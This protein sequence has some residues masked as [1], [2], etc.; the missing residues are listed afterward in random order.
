MRTEIRRLREYQQHCRKVLDALAAKNDSADILDRLRNGEAIDE[1]SR[2]LEAS[3]MS[4]TPSQPLPDG[5]PDTLNSTP[6]FPS[7]Q[8]SPFLFEDFLERSPNQSGVGPAIS[9]GQQIILGDNIDSQDLP[10]DDGPK[11]TR[12]TW[13]AVTSDTVMLSLCTCSI[14][15]LS[16]HIALPPKPAIIQNVEDALWIPYT[17]DGEPLDR[18]FDQPSNLRS[19]YKTFCEL[20]EI[21]HQALYTLYSPGF[22][23]T[24]GSLIKVYNSYIEWYDTIPDSLRLGQNFTPSVLFAHLFYHSATLLLFQPFI[25]LK[26]LTSAVLPRE[27]CTQA[28]DAITGLVKSYSDLYTLRR[29]PS[30]VPF[31]VLQSSIIH[32]LGLKHNPSDTSVRQKF[33]Q[34]ISG[35]KEMARCHGFALRAIDVVQ[36]FARH[37]KVDVDDEIGTSSRDFDRAALL[38]FFSVDVGALGLLQS[39]DTELAEEILPLFSPFPMQ[40]IPM[41]KMGGEVEKD[42]F[43]RHKQGGI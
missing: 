40:G 15:H 31:F 14:P 12:E 1:I 24:S 21:V 42:G 5:L 10:S 34:G 27:V 28:A 7:S 32:L 18:H 35:L 41:M 6:N 29:T 13:T 22:E 23:L 36:Y 2:R 43:A 16:R 17:D 9:H 25:N 38:D 4:E 30:F 39:V 3:A 37:W 19:V 26:L 33:S 20:S 8:H 11:Q